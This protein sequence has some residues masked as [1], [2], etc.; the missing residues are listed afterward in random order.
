MALQ[1]GFEAISFNDAMDKLKNQRNQGLK[2]DNF[3]FGILGG[4]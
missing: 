2:S 3:S 4:R 1:N